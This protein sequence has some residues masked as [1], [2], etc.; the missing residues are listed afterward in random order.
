MPWSA[1]GRR[2]CARARGQVGLRPAS[3]RQGPH[4]R[5]A[6]GGPAYVHFRAFTGG[7]EEPTKFHSIQLQEKEVDG[8]PTFKAIF[9]KD[10]PLDW[11][12]A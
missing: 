10:D 3:L 9:T 7:P 8:K 12:D 2:T 11:F 6:E 5:P 4:P 1:S